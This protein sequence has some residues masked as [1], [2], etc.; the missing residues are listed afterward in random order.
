MDGSVFDLALFLAATFTAA[1]VAGVSGF[2]F[3]LIAASVWLH[4]FT[5]IQ[6]AALTISY[7]ILVQGYGAW[8][9]KDAF[10]WSRLWPFILGGVPGVMMGVL[11]LRWANP[12]V[13][14]TVIAVFLVFYSLYG[15]LRPQLKPVGGGAAADAGVGFLGGLFGAMAG[16]PGILVVIWCGMRGWSRDE[17]R[18]VFQPVSVALLVMAEVALAV[19]GS[20]TAHTVRFFLIGLPALVLGTWAGFA[21]YGRL[22]D[23]LFRKIVLMLLLASGLVLLASFR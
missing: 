3:A 13:M 16:F 19:S 8:K 21:V 9:L 15:L 14:R 20:I 5:P 18:A 2:A 11:V 17:Q 6:T 23:E 1:F 22:N 7:G 10:L 12:A 4:I